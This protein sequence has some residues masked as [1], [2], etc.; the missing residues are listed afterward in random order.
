MIVEA[1]N[2][3]WKVQSKTPTE[4]L[5]AEVRQELRMRRVVMSDINY[6]VPVHMGLLEQTSPPRE[7]TR[8]MSIGQNSEEPLRDIFESM[9]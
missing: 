5:R 1:E 4:R 3:R 2:K 7:F 6:K 8:P 9:S